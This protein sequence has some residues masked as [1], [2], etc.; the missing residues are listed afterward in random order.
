MEINGCAGSPRGAW[1]EIIFPL[2]LFAL[3]KILNI[4]YALRPMEKYTTYIFVTSSLVRWQ[5]GSVSGDTGDMNYEL[6]Y[7]WR[8][9]GIAS[10]G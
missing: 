6:H 2:S 5:S 10:N 8:G 7:L 3:S 9:C 1:D 4:S